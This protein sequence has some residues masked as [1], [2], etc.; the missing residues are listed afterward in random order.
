IK[1]YLVL[2]QADLFWFVCVTAFD[3]V[4]LAVSYFFAYKIRGNVSFL[5]SF[6]WRVA[7]QLLKDSWPLILST[8]VVMIYMRIDQ[9]MIKEILGDYEVG[10][11]S[12]A[13]RL[14]EVIYFIP[15]LIA[16]S[17]FPAIL[18]AK[19]ISFDLYMTRI[20]N[21]YRMMVILAGLF[22]VFIFI[23]HDKII[24]Y[25]YGTQY[26]ESA[27]ILKVYSFS[28]VF[29]FLMMVSGNWYIAQNYQFLALG[30]NVVAVLVNVF[31]NL[32]LIPKFGL[33]GAAYSTIVSF[34]FS[35]F[36]FDVFSSKTRGQ[37]K[38]KVKSMI[39]FLK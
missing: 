7:K 11:Y 38:L 39:L 3:T 15:A 35:G 36:L 34:F 6:K 4:S 2:M 29:V 20:Y 5:R 25:L 14:I 33:V 32:I 9:I 37:F 16:K 19:K 10:I 18:N 26:L 1:I 8:V 21:I 31:L 13:V 28:I 30:R 12:A 27:E 23:L 22:I 17:L 24:F